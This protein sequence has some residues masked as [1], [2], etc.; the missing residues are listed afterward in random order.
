M[1]FEACCFTPEQ[2]VTFLK[3][4]LGPKLASDHPNVKIMIFDHNKDGKYSV[5]Y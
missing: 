2:A 1:T 4:D 5:F 3:E